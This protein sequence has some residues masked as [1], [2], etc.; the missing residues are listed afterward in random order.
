M[1][2]LTLYLDFNLQIDAKS[3]LIKTVRWFSRD[4]YLPAML[5]DCLF[6]YL[7]LRNFAT[8]LPWRAVPGEPLRTRRNPFVLSLRLRSLAQS[9]ARL[10]NIS[11][12]IRKLVSLQ[13]HVLACFPGCFCILPA[14]IS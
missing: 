4:V 7:T 5:Q 6:Y 14:S 10:R 2:C 3:S 11:Y 8:H 1:I 9:V 12:Y 13:G